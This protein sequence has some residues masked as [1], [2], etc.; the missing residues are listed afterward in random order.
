MRADKLVRD[1]LRYSQ[2]RLAKGAS[3]LPVTVVV[4]ARNEEQTITPTLGRITELAY[5]GRVEVI[6]A[7]NNSTDRTA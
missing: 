7:D 4:A 1:R 5:G 2:R 6:L 3:G